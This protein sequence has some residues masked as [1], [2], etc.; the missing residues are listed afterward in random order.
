MVY[1]QWRRPLKLA[2]IPNKDMFAAERRSS[3]PIAMIDDENQEAVVSRLE[4]LGFS[5]NEFRD[6][7]NI[8]AIA[9]YPIIASD[10]K[11][12]GKLIG[13]HTEGAFLVKE[14]RRGYPDKYIISYSSAAYDLNYTEYWKDCDKSILR[15]DDIAQWVQIFDAAIKEMADPVLRPKFND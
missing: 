7:K 1:F 13:A 10:I 14:I 3:C 15:P 5:I 12:V 11:G 2:D 8:H 6:I 4:Y 9:A